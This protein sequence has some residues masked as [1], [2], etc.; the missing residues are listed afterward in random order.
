MAFIDIIEPE[1]AD[2][3]L[4]EIYKELEQKRGKLAQIH[5]IQS[6]NPETITTHMDLLHVYYV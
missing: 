4:K 2:G 5:K 6:L 3:K 1:E